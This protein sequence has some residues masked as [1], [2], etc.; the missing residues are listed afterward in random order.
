MVES[1]FFIFL[2]LFSS[3]SITIYSVTVR[4]VL[5]HIHKLT[6]NVD[7]SENSAISQKKVSEDSQI[8]D[9]ADVM[10]VFVVCNLF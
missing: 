2:P 8:K 5:F 3:K 7:S 6:S 1:V 4:L 10:Y 9:P